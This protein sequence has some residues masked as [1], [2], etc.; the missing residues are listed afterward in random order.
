MSKYEETY[1]TAIES[2]S[3]KIY[4]SK[5]NNSDECIKIFINIGNKMRECLIINNESIKLN[6]IETIKKYLCILLCCIVNYNKT[7]NNI[8]IK[9]TYEMSKN[10]FEKKN[11]DYGDAFMDFQ[12]LGILVRL[13]DKI[14]RLES[15]LKKNTIHFESINDT[16]LDSFNY[17]I[18]ALILL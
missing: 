15:L 7:K 4:N 5:L 6:D 1:N 2:I 18:L 3:Y 13:N 10:L 11:S 9:D 16:I 8:S 14:K 12:S 17:V